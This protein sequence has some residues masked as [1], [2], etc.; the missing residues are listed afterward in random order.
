MVQL[1]PER[2]LEPQVA[3]P[4]ATGLT[5]KEPAP[6]PADSPLQTGDMFRRLGAHAILYWPA[7][8]DST[9]T[10]WSSTVINSFIRDLNDRDDLGIPEDFDLP[11]LL[12][13]WCP[14]QPWTPSPKPL[15]ESIGA[16]ESFLQ[17][18]FEREC[19]DPGWRNS[20]VVA[21]IAMAQPHL[22]LCIPN[23]RGFRA[24]HTWDF[25]TVARNYLYGFIYAKIGTEP[26]KW[27]ERLGINK[28]QMG[29]LV[30]LCTHVL[31]SLKDQNIEPLLKKMILGIIRHI[32]SSHL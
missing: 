20:L 6:G 19:S 4:V 14:A 9:L 7:F 32:E 8:K 17:T 21:A 3:A 24:Q 11:E 2:L 5:H 16:L 1:N 25:G 18:L 31:F 10:S 26:D 15:C 27:F 29:V 28:A 23:E 12:A 30:R 22:C 13:T